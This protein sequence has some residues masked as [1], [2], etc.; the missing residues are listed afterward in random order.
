VLELS[1]MPYATN[2][3][4]PAPVARALLHDA[5]GT[6]RAAFNN[7]GELPDAT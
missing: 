7:A 4:L 2:T 1:S 5:Q 6:Y 3:D